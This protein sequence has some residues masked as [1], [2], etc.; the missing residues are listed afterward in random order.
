MYVV[1]D[2]TFEQAKSIL[3][4]LATELAEQEASRFGRPI[5]LRKVIRRSAGAD[6]PI[7][8]EAEYLSTLADKLEKSYPMEALIPPQTPKA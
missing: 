1:E 3:S 6:L 4:T 5:D 7:G 2:E 8:G